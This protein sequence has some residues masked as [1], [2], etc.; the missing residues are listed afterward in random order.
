MEVDESESATDDV[1]P[2]KR[3]P[4]KELPQPAVT[5]Q[6]SQAKKGKKNKKQKK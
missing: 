3:K 2:S 4:E 1:K 5:D 6:L